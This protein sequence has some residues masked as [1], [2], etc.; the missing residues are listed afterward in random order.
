MYKN[1][2]VRLFFLF[3]FCNGSLWAQEYVWPTNASKSLT[4]SFA[5]YRSGHFHAGI[6][7]K[8]WGK[9]G[10]KV[11]AT[12]AGYIWKVRISPFGYGKVIYQILDSGEIAVYGHLQKFSPELEIIMKNEQKRRQHYSVTKVFNPNDLLV[13]KG[14]LIAYTG[15][16]GIGY[17]HL[18]FE[19]RKDEN[20]PINPLDKKFKI[21]DTI[22]P[23]PL[24]LAF[25]PLN[26]GSQV[27]GFPTPQIFKL[28]R[29]NNKSYRVQKPIQIWGII[30][31]GID[32]FDQA[33]GVNNKF[34]IYRITLYLDDLAIFQSNYQSFTYD[35]TSQINLDRNYWFIANYGKRFYNLY[36]E[37]ENT[38]NF[39]AP[40]SQENGIIYTAGY[41]KQ[42]QKEVKHYSS[43]FP[44][45]LESSNTPNLDQ[46]YLQFQKNSYTMINSGNHHCRIVLED[47][48]N[49][50]T[51]I[52]FTL[53][54]KRKNLPEQQWINFSD[55]ITD[56]FLKSNKYKW[57][58]RSK[59]SDWLPVPKPEFPNP[60]NENN[61]TKQSGATEDDNRRNILSVYKI[62]HKNNDS[63][64][65]YPVFMFT[66]SSSKPPKIDLRTIIKGPFTVF[67]FT[68]KNLITQPLLAEIRNHRLGTT[69]LNLIAHDLTR[70]T[71]SIPSFDISND[72][73]EI[74]VSSK[75]KKSD[76]FFKEKFYF[77]KIDKLKGKTII[78]KDGCLSLTIPAHTSNQDIYLS[79]ENTNSNEFVVKIPN[80]SLSQIYHIYP[81]D[82]P[83]FKSV[84]LSMTINPQTEKIQQVGI[85]TP[86][87][88]TKKWNFV[89]NSFDKSRSKFEASL[90]SLGYFTLIRDNRPP[91]V[92]IISPKNGSILTNKQP[93]IHIR[94]RDNLSKISGEEN[95]GLILDGKFCISE[96]DPELQLINFTPEEPL[97]AG[98]HQLQF[99][100]TDRA[101]NRSQKNISFTIKESNP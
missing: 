96:L 13:K 8:T 62:E 60:G 74:I 29:M 79:L 64:S 97:P 28:K 4:S 87:I 24:E 45:V 15:R 68:S 21:K 76:V 69:K 43:L 23:R 95:F 41:T 65:N 30:G 34:S 12:R 71:A 42:L 36:I 66:K 1:L 6:D 93:E 11:F 22:S 63:E 75:E 101:G 77:H 57:Y 27:N 59:S 100:M 80:D 32:A 38:L 9:E 20:T 98:T 56:Y 2:I 3:I 85:Y 54:A 44:D 40:F 48:F 84:N 51:T 39:Y 83:F 47:Y 81:T 86:N 31:L 26:L 18:H 49:N 19:L 88:R 90:K 17:P 89:S 10:Y 37:P 55:S 5:E 46:H 94:Y 35:K 7:I 53:L 50:Q 33:N 72:T 52:E 58:Q 14:Q 91:T 92:E 61:V 70:F 99:W 78:S 73:S 82:V 67:S 25:I 16:T